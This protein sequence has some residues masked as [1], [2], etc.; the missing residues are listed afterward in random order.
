MTAAADPTASEPSSD[1]AVAAAEADLARLRAEAEAAEA[2][3]KAAQA[4]AALAAA[5]AAAAKARIGSAPTAA[6]ESAVPAAAEAPG[7]ATPG[8]APVAAA[9]GPA[10]ALTANPPTQESDPQPTPSAPRPASSDP[11]TPGTLTREEVDKVTAGYTFEAATLDLGA[12][13]NGE[14][15]P[16]AQIRI[17][18]GMMNRHGLVAGATG[19]GKTRTLQGLAEQL[20]AKG[21]PVFA[22]DIKG[23]LSGVATPGE[24]SEKLLARTRAIGQDWKPEASVTEYFA[25]GGV[26]KGVPVRATVSGFGPLL[27]S[28][29]LGLNAT[30]ES[31]LGLV[32]HY[33]DA[34]GLALVDLSDLRAVLTHL[35]SD[36]GKAELKELGG[37]SAATAG[38]ILRELITFADAGAD[39]FFGEP[40]FDVA[41]FIRTAPDGRGVISLLEVP[42]VIDKPAL[43]ST[44]LMY[45]LAELFEILPEV[46]DADKPKLVFFFD[47]AHLLFKDASKD[48]LA[49]IVQTVRLIRSKG[50]GVFFVTQTPKDVPSDVLGQ[51]GSRV[52]HALR[53]FTPDDAKALRATVGTYPK[54]GYDL[55]R[56][57]QELGT[58]EAIVTVMSEK[59][60]PTPVAWTR[61]RAPQ[62]LMSPTPD[63]AIEAAVKASPL[64]AK[65]GTAI[66]RESAREILTAK[67]RAADDAAAA[68]EAELAKAKADAEY[69]KQKAAIDKQQAASDKAAAAAEKKAQQEYERLLKKTAG[70]S[71]T[72]RSAQKSPIEQ[73]LNSK[74]TQTIL[75]GVIRGIFGTG[76]R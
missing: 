73:I 6:A 49:A 64:L 5:E 68:E 26:G 61:L 22:A 25:L 35:T 31:S 69:A 36:E 44:F 54:S 62:G 42:G 50:V 32:F 48:F 18:L 75:G 67:M 71:R 51:L 8:E 34:N 74:S 1:P 43:F 47:E 19:T 3:L 58:G 17:P 76:R 11:A 72:S 23:D 40:E 13:V 24:T 4:R 2:Q 38:V 41:D 70:T 14:P 9:P 55:E 7:A 15:V 20:A 60:A 21:V 10:G 39:V 12:L 57:L 66:D 27:L 33:A 63:P 37:L 45:L 56:V 16:E 30:Q 28:K 53:A 59:G 65:Y 29:V 46:G 52:Q